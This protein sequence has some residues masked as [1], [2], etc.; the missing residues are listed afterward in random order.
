MLILWER[1]TAMAAALMLVILLLLRSIGN[2]L[3][4]CLVPA[5]CILVVVLFMLLLSR[6]A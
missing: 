3:T 2:S 1:R 6:L 5:K 4:P